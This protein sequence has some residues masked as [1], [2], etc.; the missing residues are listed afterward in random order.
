MVNKIP[1]ELVNVIG[2]F[3]WFW[4]QLTISR[5]TLI[6][7]L[8]RYITIFY[9]STF[10]FQQRKG[11]GAADESKSI[12]GGAAPT[13]QQRMISVYHHGRPPPPKPSI[14]ANMIDATTTSAIN[15]RRSKTVDAISVVLFLEVFAES[16]FNSMDSLTSQKIN[17]NTKQSYYTSNICCSL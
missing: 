17:T 9:N 1:E 12:I 13:T 3:C 5:N 7:V 14:T 15:G 8:C 6:I 4:F 16:V 11:G 10:L 2:L